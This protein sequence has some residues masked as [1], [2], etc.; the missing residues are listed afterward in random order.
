MIAMRFNN[1]KVDIRHLCPL[2]QYSISRW[3]SLIYEMLIFAKK[4]THG[5]KFVSLQ[6][7]IFNRNNNCF[8]R[9]CKKNCHIVPPWA[10]QLTCHCPMDLTQCNVIKLCIVGFGVG[11]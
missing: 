5:L 3:C 7:I 6:I 11:G 4:N 8:N 9:K 2:L 10:C 1:N